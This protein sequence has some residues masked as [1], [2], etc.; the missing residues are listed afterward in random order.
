MM[1]Q[2]DDSE[3][4]ELVDKPKEGSLTEGP[5]PLPTW[6][7]PP[8]TLP[9]NLMSGPSTL[10]LPAGQLFPSTSTPTAGNPQFFTSPS[11]AVNIFSSHNCKCYFILNN[12]FLILIFTLAVE[13]SNC[14]SHF[15]CNGK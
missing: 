7:N 6:I 13:S 10:L 12:A 1:N 3:G 8:T 15:T 2:Q 5:A 4:F 11:S 14:S 9:I